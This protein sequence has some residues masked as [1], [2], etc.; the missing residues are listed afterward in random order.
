MKRLTFTGY[1]DDTFACD[2]PAID[3][4]YDTCASGKPVTMRVQSVADDESLLVVGQYAPGACAGWLIG[5]APDEGDDSDDPM[6][7]WPMRYEPNPNVP[8]SP[9]LV[10][11]APDDVQVVVISHA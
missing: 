7:P 5:V 1:S 8:Y 6:P 3:V 9:L 4:D 2:G 10:I 11:D